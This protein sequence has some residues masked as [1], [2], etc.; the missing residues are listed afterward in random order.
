MRA[1]LAAAVAVT[2][3]AA[4]PSAA[5]AAEHVMVTSSAVSFTRP[6][7]LGSVELGR[8]VPFALTRPGCDKSV[9][10][11][12]ARFGQV[13]V[14]GP[15]AHGCSGRASIPRSDELA[16]RGWTEGT[17]LEVDLTSGDAT[18]ALKHKHLEPDL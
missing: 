3:C 12:V 14:D 1:V 10:H 17:P 15:A 18:L 13:Q 2:T 16:A 5:S 8:E 11:V 9:T 7:A 6:A 4:L